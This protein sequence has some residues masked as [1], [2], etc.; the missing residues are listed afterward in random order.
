[1]L[2]IGSV[3]LIKNDCKLAEDYKHLKLI[4]HC[5]DRPL[6]GI[7]NVAFV[8]IV[9]KN[10]FLLLQNRHYKNTDFIGSSTIN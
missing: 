7:S 9:L 6:F 2:L 4:W 1:M 5:D 10:S 3:A 8:S